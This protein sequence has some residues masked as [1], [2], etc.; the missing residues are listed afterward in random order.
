MTT[1]EVRTIVLDVLSSLAPE[2]DIGQIQ[3]DAD[4]REQFDLDSMDV[5]NFAIGLH[6][7]TGAQIP[8]VDYPKLLTLNGAVA[9]LAP[10]LPG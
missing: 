1:D 3:P 9:Y 6:E 5:L 2:I 8:E 7:R 4:L 10:K